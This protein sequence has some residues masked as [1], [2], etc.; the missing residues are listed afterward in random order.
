MSVPI[1]IIVRVNAIPYSIDI[2]ESESQQLAT[3]FMYSGEFRLPCSE[4]REAQKKIGQLLFAPLFSLHIPY[5]QLEP[6]ERDEFFLIAV[7][8]S[9]LL[10]NTRTTRTCVYFFYEKEIGWMLYV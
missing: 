7:L 2:H 1:H 5:R 10:Y 9:E 4:G 8:E 6:N 3:C